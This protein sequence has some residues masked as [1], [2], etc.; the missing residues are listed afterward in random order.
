MSLVNV[1][2]RVFRPA[3]RYL[4]RIAP[5]IHNLLLLLLQQFKNHFVNKKRFCCNRNN[6]TRRRCCVP[7]TA[8]NSELFLAG[9]NIFVH[10]GT[11]RQS[12]SKNH[13]D[14]AAAEC[15]HVQKKAS[16]KVCEK[17]KKH[18]AKRVR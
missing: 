11:Q 3:G 16:A 12:N 13:R 10:N 2:T 7:V 15:D 5:L 4:Y 14:S 8:N 1:P 9:C 17:D 6:N 18:N